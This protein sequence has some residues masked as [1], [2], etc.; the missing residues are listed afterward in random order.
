MNVKGLLFSGLLL[1][2]LLRLAS[3]TLCMIYIYRQLAVAAAAV[4]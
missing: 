4:I 3:F 1:M 2:V